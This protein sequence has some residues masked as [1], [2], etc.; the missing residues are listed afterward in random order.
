MASFF[1]RVDFVLV[2]GKGR[3]SEICLLIRGGLI[4]RSG[5]TGFLFCLAPVLAL[6]FL[7]LQWADR[8]AGCLCRKSKRFASHSASDLGQVL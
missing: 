8:F 5:V 6:G 1:P 3:F 4:I 2:N 7:V